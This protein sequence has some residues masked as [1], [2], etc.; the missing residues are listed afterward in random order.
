MQSRKINVKSAILGVHSVHFKRVHDFAEKWQY[1]QYGQTACPY[2]KPLSVKELSNMDN[3]DKHFGLSI[4]I[5]R[6][7]PTT[8]R[9]GQ[10]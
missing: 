7:I 5:S 1:G 9:Y 4:F 2:Y 8:S 10:T 3:M 6:Y